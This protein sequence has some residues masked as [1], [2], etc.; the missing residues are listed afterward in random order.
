MTALKF[1]ILSVGTTAIFAFHSSMVIFVPLL[2][3]LQR[4]K[5]KSANLVH[6][7]APNLFS[8]LVRSADFLGTHHSDRTQEIGRHNRGSRFSPLLDQV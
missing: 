3:S 7:S 8:N 2:P 1:R 5:P 4:L 6:T